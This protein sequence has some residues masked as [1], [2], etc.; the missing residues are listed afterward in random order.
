M[1]IAVLPL[2]VVVLW[3]LPIFCPVSSHLVNQWSLGSNA[4]PVPTITGPVPKMFCPVLTTPIPGSTP[5][6]TY[7]GFLKD[8][9]LSREFPDYFK[10]RSLY[11]RPKKFINVVIAEKRRQPGKKREDE[12]LKKPHEQFEDTEQTEKV[13][14]IS[15]IGKIDG[16]NARYI[17]VE[18]ARGVGKTTLVWHL[19]RLWAMDEALQQWRTVILVQLRHTRARNATTFK[20]LLYH[21]E[22]YVRQAVVNEIKKTNGKGILLI[23]EGYDELNNKQLLKDGI[24]MRLL[25]GDELPAASIMVTSRP[26]TSEKFP[27][28]FRDHPYLQHMEVLGY[29]EEDV[30]RHVEELCARNPKVIENFRLFMK[31]H[32]SVLSAMK[33]PFHCAILSGIYVLHWEKGKQEFA[34]KTVK[35]MYTILVIAFVNRELSTSTESTTDFLDAEHLTSLPLYIY[36]ELLI[37]AKL[38]QVRKYRFDSQTGDLYMS[39]KKSS[40]ANLHLQVQEYFSGLYLVRNVKDEQWLKKK[41]E[42]DLLNE[43]DLHVTDSD[44]KQLAESYWKAFLFF[45]G[46][47]KL[48]NEFIQDHLSLMLMV[49]NKNIVASVLCD[50]L[51][52]CQCPHSTLKIFRSSRFQRTPLEYFVH[53]YCIA[54]SHPTSTWDLQFSSDKQI[55]MLLEGMQYTESAP[56]MG[57]SIKSMFTSFPTT[58]LFNLHPHTKNLEKLTLWLIRNSP[59]Q[60]E[61]VQGIPK[62]FPVLQNLVLICQGSLK[63]YKGLFAVLP[64]LAMLTNLQVSFNLEDLGIDDWDP[65]YQ[66]K[67]CPSLKTFNASLPSNAD[68][69]YSL[70]IMRSILP[71]LNADIIESLLLW[72]INVSLLSSSELASYLQSSTCSLH[73]LE[74][75]DHHFS[76]LEAF[77]NLVHAATI[78]KCLRKLSFT[79]GVMHAEGGFVLADR[80]AVVEGALEEIDLFKC[81]G[82]ISD[83]GTLILRNAICSSQNKQVK[84]HLSLDYKETLESTLTPAAIKEDRITIT[85]DLCIKDPE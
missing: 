5:M 84:L 47:T 33:N 41:D 68:T 49:P 2:M 58:E 25:R 1:C 69:N 30:F 40:Y 14:N 12:A 28:H 43:S 4:S 34:P 38:V 52:V 50:L 7:L 31:G 55:E 22:D 60:S 72:S 29:K 82:C 66:L 57:G 53:G 79:H 16:G 65:F 71:L 11:D 6:D 20:D 62:Y 32:P 23:L 39:D 17:F 59:S 85:S 9:Y 45:I 42:D 56:G 78:S 77:E 51:F 75:R 26:V 24:L 73:T 80:L 61:F 37:L 36:S 54:H 64:K 21:P 19:C 44:S 70:S 18:G 15:S 81:F 63:D 35:E 27:E 83:E 3:L 46:L 8:T 67:H 76:S 48:P 13:I 10:G 74:L